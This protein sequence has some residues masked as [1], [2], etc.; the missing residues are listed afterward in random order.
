MLECSCCLLAKKV[1]STLKGK[2]LL[3]LDHSFCF[4]CQELC[5]R[6]TVAVMLTAA[7]FILSQHWVDG[8]CCFKSF[9]GDPFQSHS[10]ASW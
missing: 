7:V 8:V 3:L 2:R 6:I 9:F 10:S 1:R 5:S 4:L